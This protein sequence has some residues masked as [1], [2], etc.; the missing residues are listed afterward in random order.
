[1]NQKFKNPTPIPTEKT[2]HKAIK[3]V[4]AVIIQNSLKLPIDSI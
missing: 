3:M 1:M 2:H 4:D